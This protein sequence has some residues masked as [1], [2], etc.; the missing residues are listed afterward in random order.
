MQKVVRAVLDE[1]EIDGMHHYL[2]YENRV[3]LESAHTPMISG[4]MMFFGNTTYI[5][6]SK[7]LA[8][9]AEVL[10]MTKELTRLRRL[11]RRMVARWNRE[12]GNDQDK[13]EEQKK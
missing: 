2:T 13:T 9:E 6:Y 5:E 4:G 11:E 10:S 12:H 1:Y 8:L 3:F 7:Y